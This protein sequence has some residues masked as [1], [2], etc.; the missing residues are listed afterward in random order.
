[1]GLI[2]LKE[3]KWKHQKLRFPEYKKH[4]LG[5][6]LKCNICN[7]AVVWIFNNR[8]YNYTRQNGR[9]KNLNGKDYKICLCKDKKDV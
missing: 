9:I 3:R 4:M 5:D 2:L 1:L 7:S 8:E 6:A